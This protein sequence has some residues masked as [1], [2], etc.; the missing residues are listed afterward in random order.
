MLGAWIPMLEAPPR[1]GLI[2][3]N[4][5]TKKGDM[6]QL[7]LQI[8][9]QHYVNLGQIAEAVHRSPI[10]LQNHI[11]AHMVKSGKLKY[12]YP[13]TPNHPN[14]AYKSAEE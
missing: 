2:T 5:R 4:K 11:L 6:E 9:S 1:N 14:Q 3:N 10:Y 8:C 13:E 12:K 7:I